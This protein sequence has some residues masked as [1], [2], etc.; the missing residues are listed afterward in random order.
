MIT[1]ALCMIYQLFGNE[2]N[3]IISEMNAEVVAV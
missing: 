3:T 1:R 2:M